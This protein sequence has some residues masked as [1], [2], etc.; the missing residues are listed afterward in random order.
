M[1][2]KL[3]HQNFNNCEN[4]AW[5]IFRG[6][7]C[8]E[9]IF[10]RGPNF[11]STTVKLAETIDASMFSTTFIVY[12]SWGIISS[13]SCSHLES[14]VIF[15]NF[16]FSTFTWIESHNL[17]VQYLYCSFCRHSVVLTIIKCN[18]TLQDKLFCWYICL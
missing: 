3:F 6:I 2:S 4:S 17:L 11:V 15:T 16:F 9:V 18:E 1:D 13:A 14:R 8:R 10:C 7:F 5:T 12:I